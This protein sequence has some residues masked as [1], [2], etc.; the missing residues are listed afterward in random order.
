[1]CA[2]ERAASIMMGLT[3]KRSKRNGVWVERIRTIEHPMVC[4]ACSGLPDDSSSGVYLL[5]TPSTSKRFCRKCR[6]RGV[7]WLRVSCAQ[8]VGGCSSRLSGG[9]LLLSNHSLRQHHVLPGYVLPTWSMPIVG[10]LSQNLFGAVQVLVTYPLFFRKER[11][12]P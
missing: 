9:V 12:T 11:R 5:F 1:M 6:G 8:E 7:S 10:S 3:G 2:G 4:C